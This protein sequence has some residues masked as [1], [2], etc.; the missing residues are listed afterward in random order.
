MKAR[1]RSILLEVLGCVV[2]VQAGL[3]DASCNNPSLGSAMSPSNSAVN[4]SK[5][6]ANQVFHSAG[7]FLLNE[8]TLVRKAFFTQRI[9]SGWLTVS[10]DKPNAS[11]QQSHFAGKVGVR[12][13]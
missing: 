4:A 7:V 5:A 1:D 9:A 11:P 13:F 6:E 10:H 3:V 12:A 2:V 8:E